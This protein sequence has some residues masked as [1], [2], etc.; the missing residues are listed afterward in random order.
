MVMEFNAA[1]ASSLNARRASRHQRQFLSAQLWKANAGPDLDATLLKGK[2]L[3]GIF[4]MTVAPSK[5]HSAFFFPSSMLFSGEVLH[6]RCGETRCYELPDV[7]RGN[8]IPLYEYRLAI[9]SLITHQAHTPENWG[10]Q[11][12]GCQPGGPAPCRMTR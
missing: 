12:S 9:P 6:S 5:K 8:E 4:S 1:A 10:L 11:I 2:H 3:P 7:R